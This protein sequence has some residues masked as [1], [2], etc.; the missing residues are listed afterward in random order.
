MLE[1]VWVYGAMVRYIALTVTFFSFLTSIATARPVVAELFVSQNCEACPGAIKIMGEKAEE[2]GEDLLLLTW[3]VDYWDYLGSSDDMALPEASTRQRAYA[4][5]M[6]I[7][8]PYTPQVVFNGATHCPGNRRRSV[9]REIQ[10]HADDPFNG[11]D[12]DFNPDVTNLTL[13]SPLTN[14]DL[15]VSL[16]EYETMEH[17]NVV[18]QNAVTAHQLLGD[19]SGKDKTFPIQCET[20][21][22]VII[23]EA[24][25]GDI[26][27]ATVVP[28]KTTIREAPR[29][30]PTGLQ[31]ER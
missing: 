18:L 27:Y 25:Y 15:V 11:F 16:V 19:W 4:E 6:S 10:E 12:V 31:S 23:Q 8:G 5:N 26:L 9:N 29:D 17:G 20:D 21:C 2:Q 14:L 7:R 22:A 13:G 3:S 24:D 30:E 28:A 1:K